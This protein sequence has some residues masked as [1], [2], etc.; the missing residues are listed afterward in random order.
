MQY[1]PGNSYPSRMSQFVNTSADQGGVHINSS[2]INHCFYQLAEGMPNAIGPVDAGRIFYRALTAHLTSY[3]QFKDARIAC[4]TSAEELFGAN[5]SQAQTVSEAFDLVEVGVA[6]PSPGPADYNEVA[7]PDSTLFLFVDAPSGNILLGRRDTDEGDGV[8]G[9]SLD[10]TVPLA[11]QRIAVSGN[12]QLAACVTADN[13]LGLVDIYGAATMDGLPAINKLG[14]PGT[15]YTVTVDPSGERYAFVLLDGTGNPTNQISVVDVKAN[16]TRT[17]ELEAA[18]QDGGSV[19]PTVDFAEAMAFTADGRFLIYDALNELTIGSVTLRNWSIY[20]LDLLTE[21]TLSVVP[22]FIG[23]DI[24]NPSLSQTSDG[25]LTFEVF[26]QL[27]QQSTVY[28]GD[29]NEGTLVAVATVTGGFPAFPS[30]TG[31]DA[32]I[33]YEVPDSAMPTGLSILHQPVAGRLTPTSSPTTWIQDAARAVIYR[34]G[35]FVV[36]NSPP[37]ATIDTPVSNVTINQGQSVQF[38][39]T[40]ND[41]NGHLPLAFVWDF[42]GGATSSFVEDPGAVR[43]DQAGVYTVR[44]DSFDSEGLADPSPALR[45]VTV[46]APPPPPS[47]GGGGCAYNPNAEFDPTLVLM[48]I[49]I[50]VWAQRRRWV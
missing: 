30:Y 36:P 37:D 23:L 46:L 15:V 14:F 19:V 27:L 3:A 16:T 6:A 33:I 1:P 43:F 31:D 10:P 42:D 38:S 7:G 49:G 4:V 21:T 12:G 25:F 47:G 18:T 9:I 8:A 22:P 34:R 13:D 2:I 39:A 48:I 20:A 17:F 24:G 45:T 44:L 5:S 26:D 35:V 50:Y 29:L 28:A 11:A 32:A 40:G 41:V